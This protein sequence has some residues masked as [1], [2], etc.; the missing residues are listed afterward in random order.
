MM[1][2]RNSFFVLIIFSLFLGALIQV[3]SAQD[4]TWSRPEVTS[5]PGFEAVIDGVKEESWGFKVNSSSYVLD[6]LQFKVFVQHYNQYIYFLVEARFTTEVQNETVSLFLSQSN[7]TISFLDKKQITIFNAS[8]SGN[9]SSTFSDYYLNS[10]SYVVDQFDLGFNGAAGIGE[11]GYRIFEFKIL[12]QPEENS[13]T[14]DVTLNVY[15][16]YAIELG[17]N[18]SNSD[19]VKISDPLLVQIGPKSSASTEG[20]IGEYN[21]DSE[22]FILIVLIIVSVF[23]L[24]YGGLLLATK[25]KQ[26]IQYIEQEEDV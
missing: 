3:V 9:E 21:F 17:Y 15:K 5:N 16:N 10:D 7:Q 2:K 26:G 25:K 8:E 23:V 24:S 12:L 19:E 1:R 11:N 6:G 13:T 22:L 18:N 14:E 4:E 20:E